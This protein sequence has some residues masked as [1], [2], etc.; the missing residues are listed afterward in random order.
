MTLFSIT[1]AWTL[2]AGCDADW[3]AAGRTNTA[4]DSAGTNTLNA[5]K[6]SV[7]FTAGSLCV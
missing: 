1:G 3:T 4:A 6:R 7:R 5:A 2:A